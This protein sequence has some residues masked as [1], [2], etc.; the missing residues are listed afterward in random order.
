LQLCL[1]TFSSVPAF[2]PTV[3]VRT[4]LAAPVTAHLPVAA[5]VLTPI[6]TFSTKPVF[7]TCRVTAIIG[8]AAYPTASTIK[9]TFNTLGTTRDVDRSVQT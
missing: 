2:P 4:A 5:I 1:V 8:S 9:P 3:A 7:N 6:T